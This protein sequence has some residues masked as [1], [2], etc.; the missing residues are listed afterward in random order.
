MDTTLVALTLR[1]LISDAKGDPLG[2]SDMVGVHL[3]MEDDTE[4]LNN[5]CMALLQ[6]KLT[7][8]NASLMSVPTFFC[9]S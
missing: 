3:Q 1:H 8:L 5:R 9:R 7:A 4:D 2:P 6:E